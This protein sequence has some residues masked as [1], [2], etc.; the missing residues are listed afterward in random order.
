MP[1]AGNMVVAALV[2]L[3]SVGSVVDHAGVET[4]ALHQVVSSQTRIVQEWGMFSSPVRGHRTYIVEA[5]GNDG[6]HIDLF[7]DRG[8]VG[9]DS[10][11]KVDEQFPTPP[12][13]T[14]LYDNYRWRLFFS[15]VH[16]F[17]G[18]RVSR[19]EG[20][21]HLYASYVCRSWNRR[22]DGGRQVRK[23]RLYRLFD[24]VGPFEEPYVHYG[25]SESELENNLLWVYWCF[26]EDRREQGVMPEAP[27]WGVGQ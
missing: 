16:G 9:P 20:A 27:M 14:S 19:L 8:P 23:L 17:G 11:Q 24:A 21:R 7:G 6:E 25:S 3:V 5:T 26:E 15:R 22:H 12:R 1:G 18:M 4:G 10:A 13:T 2:W